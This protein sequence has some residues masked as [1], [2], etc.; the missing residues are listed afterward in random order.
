MGVSGTG[1]VNQLLA[2]WC[3]LQ[4]TAA[5]QAALPP[6]QLRCHTQPPTPNPAGSAHP[7]HKLLA[8]LRL[9]VLPG[10]GGDVAVHV[11]VGAAQGHAV[12]AARDGARDNL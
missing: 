12:G 2:L 5:E 7:R 3:S 1:K 8:A 11:V 10:V 6:P 9:A 4:S